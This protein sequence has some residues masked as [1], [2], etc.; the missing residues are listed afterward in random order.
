MKN[1]TERLTD[2]ATKVGA[3]HILNTIAE[4][5]KTPSGDIHIPFSEYLRLCEP[6]QVTS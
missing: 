6:Y 3:L 1:D 5:Y 2:L 4:K